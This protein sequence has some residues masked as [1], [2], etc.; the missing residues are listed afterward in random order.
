[1][2]GAGPV[3]LTDRINTGK[4]CPTR[5]LLSLGLVLVAAVLGIVALA[6][7]DTSYG[8]WLRKAAV[9]AGALGVLLLAG[10]A[11]GY[12]LRVELRRL[13]RA[14]QAANRSEQDHVDALARLDA[15]FQN[16]DDSMLI[17]RLN[18]AGA[19]VYDAVN[20][21]WERMTGVSAAF[22]LGNTPAACLPDCLATEFAARWEQCRH[23]RRTVTFAFETQFGGLR[24]AWENKLVPILDQSGRVSRLIGVARDVTQRKAAEDQLAALNFE[25]SLQA[26]T[27]G[28]TGLANRRRLDEALDLEWRRAARDGSLLSMLMIDLDRFKLFNDRYGHQQGDACLKMVANVL[29]PFARRPGDIAARYGGEELAILL[30]NTG[31]AQAALIA[32]RVRAAIEAEMM[33]HEGNTPFGIVTASIG[34][35]T[36]RPFASASGDAVSELVSAADEALYEAKHT[37]RNRVVMSKR[38]AAEHV[39]RQPQLSA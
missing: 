27:D 1:M 26:T 6:L 24:R 21:V 29:G 34:V 36:L 15:L 3:Y 25:L 10:I 28:L 18:P 5:L 23:E 20:P 7:Y 16:S 19:L 32:E 11:L 4:A 14:E 35:A 22:A 30:P 2:L 37:G 31:A 17:A 38:E 12:A 33:S 13:A 9:M 8:E 39:A